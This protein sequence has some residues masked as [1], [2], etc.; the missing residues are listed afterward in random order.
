MAQF[1]T[2]LHCKPDLTPFYVGKGSL[3]RCYEFGRGRRGIHHQNIVAKYGQEN[4]QIIIFKKDSEEAAFKSEISLI[5]MLRRAGFDLCN[6]TDGGEG[7]S[8]IEFSNERREKHANA[9]MGNKYSLGYKHTPEECTKRSTRQKGKVLSPE[10]RAKLSAATRPS[11]PCSEETK[12]KISRS[13]IGNKNSVGNKTN[14]GRHPSMETRAKLS[15]AAKGRT[16]SPET[17]A[18]MAI[19]A[20]SRVMRIK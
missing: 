17:R 1:Y 6:K 10:H 5:G 20:Q 15:L 7:T 11:R 12:T 2:Y 13:L 9:A 14:L 4:I 19:S 16:H 3:K 18:K 8:G